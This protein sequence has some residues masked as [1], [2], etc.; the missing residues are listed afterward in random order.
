MEPLS[1]EASR[2]DRLVEAMARYDLE[3]DYQRQSGIW[4]E[5]KRQL[6]IDSLI[7]GYD[8]PKLYFHRLSTRD[9]PS[10]RYAI[11][12]GKQ[13]LETVDAFLKNEFALAEDFVD[14]AADDGDDASAAANKTYRQLTEEH[15]ALAGRLTQYSL[16]IVVIET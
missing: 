13:R 7:N 1:K 3:P 4:G 12:D 2:V 15:P 10:K 8:V 14:V 6:F 16:D 11:V 5:E 9:R